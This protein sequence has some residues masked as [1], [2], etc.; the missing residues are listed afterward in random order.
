VRFQIEQLKVRLTTLNASSSVDQSEAQERVHT[1]E[2]K[3]RSEMER[4]VGHAEQV[5]LYL[6]SQPARPGK[7]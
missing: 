5:A 4:L 2:I 3:L 1:T 7:N 6:R